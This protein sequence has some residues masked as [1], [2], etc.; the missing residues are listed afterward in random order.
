MEVYD[1]HVIDLLSVGTTLRTRLPVSQ[2]LEY[3]GKPL[4]YP[5]R[6]GYLIDVRD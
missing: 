5:G 1:D 4:G 6:G 3:I 2:Q